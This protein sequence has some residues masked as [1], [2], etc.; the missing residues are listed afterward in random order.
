[1]QYL[2]NITSLANFTGLDKQVLHFMCEYKPVCRE[3][4]MKVINAVSNITGKE[5]TLENTAIPLFEDVGKG[6][7]ENGETKVSPTL[8]NP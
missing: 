2:L 3:D 8:R 1:M 5:Y 4:A 6:Q 7:E